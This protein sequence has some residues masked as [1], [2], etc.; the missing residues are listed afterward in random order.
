M[1]RRDWN[2]TGQPRWRQFAAILACALLYAALAALGQM[3]AISKGNGVPVWLPTGLGL[4]AVLLCGPRMRWAVLLGAML[5]NSMIQARQGPL[6]LSG[7]LASTVIA[8]A[9]MLAVMLAARWARQIFGASYRFQRLRQVY[10]FTAASVVASVPVA[11][12]GAL[13]LLVAGNIGAADFADVAAAW[14]MSDVLAFLVVAPPLLV[15]AQPDE[16]AVQPPGRRLEAVLHAGVTLVFFMLAFG[17]PLAGYATFSCA[18]FLLL[19]CAGWA[20]WRFGQRCSS[21]LVLLVALAAWLSSAAG[22]PAFVVGAQHGTFLALGAYIGLAALTTLMAGADAERNV[23]WRAPGGRRGPIQWPPLLP[24]CVL[25]AGLAATAVSWQLV[26]DYTEQRAADNFRRI[27]QQV[28]QRVE[29]RVTDYERLLKIGAT[30]FAASHSV[31]RKEWA[32]FVAGL[33]IEQS[34]PGSASVG[35]VAWLDDDMVAA[36][37]QGM[38]GEDPAFRVRPRDSVDGHLAVVQYLEPFN[39]VNRRVWGY[40]VLSEPVRRTALLQAARSGRIAASARLTLRSE[41]AEQG[42]AAPPGFLMYHP[43]YRGG[44]DPGTEAGRMRELMGFIH[45]AFRIEDL[46]GSMAL[47]ALP[48]MDLEVTENGQGPLLYRS[49]A[50]AARRNQVFAR[51]YSLEKPVMLGET[52]HYWR[53]RVS[54]TPGY[55][56]G[57]D[58][59]KALIV[60]VLGALVS[61]LVFEMVRSLSSTRLEALALAE[62]MTRELHDKNAVLAQSETEARRVAEELLGAKERAE[63]ASQAKSAFVA[64]M[65]HELRTPMNAVLGIAQLLGRT[66]LTAEQQNYLGMIAVSGRTLLNVLNDILDF[67]KVEAGRMELS[68]TDVCIEDI[69]HAIGA[70]MAVNVGDKPI[71]AI[72]DVAPGV[73]A[74]MRL[75]AMRLEQILINLAGNALKFTQQGKVLLRFDV[76]P[77]E[78]ERRMLRLAVADT[79]PGMAPDLLPRLFSPFVQADSSMSR[80]HGGTGLGLAIAQRLARLM[81]GGITVESA[82]GHGTTFTVTV[83]YEPVAVSA[84]PATPAPALCGI[85]VLLLEED[86]DTGRALVHAAAPWNWRFGRA[87]SVEQALRLLDSIA[88]VRYA[89]LVAGPSFDVASLPPLLARMGQGGAHGGARHGA[90]FVVRLV[91]GFGTLAQPTPAA[92]RHA[93]VLHCPATRRGLLAAVL[94]AAQSASAAQAAQ[95][96]E[97][98]QAGELA[99][100]GESAQAGESVQAGELAQPGESAQAGESV[101]AGESSQAGESVQAAQAAQAVRG[102][103]ADADTGAAD[104]CASCGELAGMALL[105]AEDNAL[106]QVV[107]STMLLGAGATVDIA[108]NGLEA[109]DAMRRHGSRYDV[110]LMDV[111]MPVMD[112]YAAT[113][114]IR[115]EL[116]LHTTIIA[117][118]AGVTQAERAECLAAGMDDFIAKPVECDDMIATIARYR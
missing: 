90:P 10:L 67:S 109:L 91:S 89:G 13:T 11:L 81:G 65:S 73:P 38:R 107:A 25:H 43:V 35:Y 82:L 85:A 83:P 34:F 64:N 77:Q 20:A 2:L 97:S 75:D 78:G 40:N 14:W 104:P 98:A 53:V 62:R 61:I 31:E 71:R 27:A 116:G 111:Q 105:L 118:T 72:I 63:S 3:L 46:F 41:R 101:Q 68:E 69:A 57:I 52:G 55:E 96:G 16:G 87:A 93:A 42:K 74:C 79:G 80:R 30:Y 19:P 99:Q 6:S 33:E 17:L 54:S 18:P 8:V 26:A 112:G 44:D 1:T 84:P 58:R 59:E 37:E 100:P 94:Q 92:L 39:E 70:V 24:L 110:V 114:A 66:Q 4:A 113:R 45:A 95:A 115:T 60:L 15:W 32:R 36:Y 108:A 86:D 117:M 22:A 103:L 28:W 47:G 102:A 23:L 106:N 12:A 7:A 56:D 49:G 48:E 76:A 5:A 9:N 88:G 21:L 50:P 29:S 51:R